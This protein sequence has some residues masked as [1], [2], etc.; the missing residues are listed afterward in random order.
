MFVDNPGFITRTDQKV[1]RCQQI[2]RE[3]WEIY[4]F[5]KSWDAVYEISKLYEILIKIF[6]DNDCWRSWFY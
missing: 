4:D 3:S 5:L 2:W 1:K 6:L